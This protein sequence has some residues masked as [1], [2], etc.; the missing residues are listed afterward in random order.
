MYVSTIALVIIS[1]F[2]S[3][4]QGTDGQLVLEQ[5][6][7]SNHLSHPLHQVNGVSHEARGKGVCQTDECDLLSPY[8]LNRV[9]PGTA[10]AISTCCKRRA[11]RNFQLVSARAL[12]GIS[13]GCDSRGPRDSVCWADG[14]IQ[15]SA[16]PGH[17][18]RKETKSTSRGQFPPRFP[19]S[20]ST[21][22]APLYSHQER[23]PSPRR[24]HVAWQ[25]SRERTVSF[26]QACRERTDV[27]APAS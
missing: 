25:L 24:T 6:T 10:T 4:A 15:A 2:A 13:L 9:I 27:P 23:D 22:V 19:I 26:R 8:R 17:E 12:A 16:L 18:G 7:P 14:D 11:A 20:K 3:L 5:S 21:A 1:A